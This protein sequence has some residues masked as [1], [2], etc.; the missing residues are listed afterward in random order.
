MVLRDNIYISARS[1]LN[2]ICEVNALVC[3]PISDLTSWKAIATP[4]THYGL[5]TYRSQLVLVGGMDHRTRSTDKVW[6]SED[7]TCWD[8]KLPPMPQKRSSPYVVSSS[9]PECLIVTGGKGKDAS[10]IYLLSG[11]QWWTC[12]MPTELTSVRIL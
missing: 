8:E 11:N 4:V 2:P 6:L 1:E 9:A 10:E 12:K 5:S 3:V 7:G